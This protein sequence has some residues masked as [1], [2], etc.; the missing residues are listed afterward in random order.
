MRIELKLILVSVSVLSGCLG[1]VSSL[2]GS[3][4]MSDLE[5][6]SAF[7]CVVTG[8]EGA[9]TCQALH[10]ELPAPG[11][12]APG[13]PYY[14]GEIKTILDTYC[15]SCHGE[16]RT[17]SGIQ[18]LRLDQ[19]EDG[20]DG[21]QGVKTAAHRI[22]TSTFDFRTMPP[23]YHGLKPSEAERDAVK[24]W[25]AAGA[26]RCEDDPG[27]GSP[28]GGEDGGSSDGGSD[29]GTTPVPDAG[30]DAGVPNTAVSYANDVQPIWNL[31]CRGCHTSG[32]TRGNLNL[33][34]GVS[35]GELLNVPSLCNTSVVNVKAGDPQGSMLWRKIT[36][37]P[38]RCSGVMPTNGDLQSF[39]PEAA[40]VITRWIQQGALNN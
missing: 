6:P 9:R 35:R 17:G 10:E 5:C 36:A 38:A 28:D 21:V 34:P 14:C 24:R 23:A 30:M 4:C 31:Y 16:N 33:D 8:F 27:V 12:P 39:D 26:P 40:D 22:R 19:F 13:T 18:N 3:T 15:V 11:A 37:D 29:G 2:S 25:E 20:T 7:A 1:E 32:N